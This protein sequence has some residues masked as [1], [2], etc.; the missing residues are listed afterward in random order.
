MRTAC[1]GDRVSSQAKIALR[2]N[3]V[4]FLEFLP[5]SV[6]DTGYATETWPVIAAESGSLDVLKWLIDHG[7]A[8]DSNTVGMAV[9]KNLHP[10]VL[11]WL[12]DVHHL[13]PSEMLTQALYSEVALERGRTK[14]QVAVLDFLHVHGEFTANTA[15]LSVYMA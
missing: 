9:V 14:D 10:R 2:S 4:G 7:C 12:V 8:W 3:N 6:L 5:Q 15:V 11:R 1:T 13:Q